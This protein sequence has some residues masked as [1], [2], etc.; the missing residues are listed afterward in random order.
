MKFFTK[1]K[2]II[3][4][5][6]LFYSSCLFSQL[7][8]NITSVPD[9]TPDGGDIYIASNYN[10][11][12]PSDSNYILTDNGDGTYEITFTPTIGVLEYKFTR[13]DWATVESNEQGQDIS[14][15]TVS[16]T[17]SQ[18]SIE[19]SILS[20]KDSDGGSGS[21]EENVSIL[22]QNF[23]IPQ[24]DR[25]R[26][27]WI[28]IPPDY[29]ISD[30]SYPVIYMQDGQNLFDVNTSFS[31]EWEI[32]E[33]LNELFDN[34]DEGVIVVGIDNGG[35]D[36]INE[37][38]PWVNTTYGGGEG[39]DYVDFIVETLKPHIDSNYRTKSDRIN[40][41]I[42]GSSLGGLISFYAAIEHQ[43]VFSKAGIFSPSF[44]FSDDVYTHVQTTGKKHDMS[45][46]L[47]GGQNES[48]SMVP[49]MEAMV[50][51]L[52]NVGF[53]DSEI[54]IVTHQNGQ[55]SEWYWNREFPDA[56][57]WMFNKTILSIPFP[58]SIN[59]INIFPNP[60]S[61][62]INIIY[63]TNRVD[64]K[65]NIYKS[66]GEQVYS[67]FI[68]SPANEINLSNL[69]YGLYLFQIVENN[70]TILTRKILHIEN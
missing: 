50:T 14:N 2:S 30:T 49:D 42:M 10:G 67:D 32:D 54:R 29:D 22:D 27:I 16:Y 26:R 12:D 58:S 25:T 9:N 63:G 55:H 70:K 5:T 33:S 8:I 17:G 65:L 7:T 18:Q 53:D 23:Y 20:W 38:S 15:R 41:G 69:E 52:K 4:F 3:F 6:L 48:A 56:Y 39:D 51:T 62:T 24:L 11:W 61:D 31:G 19:V 37:Y 59:D 45:I 34:G 60:F 36:R 28:Y 43:D 1:A 46:Y 57:L 68:I 66:N 64:A 13:G 40:T 44:W 21:R 47:L 35:G